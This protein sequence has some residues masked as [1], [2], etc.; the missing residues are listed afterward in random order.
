ME[1]LLTSNIGDLCF[2]DSSGDEAVRLM[3]ERNRFVLGID[4]WVGFESVGVAMQY[5]QSCAG[6]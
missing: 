5:P 6:E 3:R 2:P 1:G 4:A